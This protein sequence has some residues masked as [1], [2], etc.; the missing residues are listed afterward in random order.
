VWANL[1]G[2]V[3]VGLI[4]I[5]LWV[6]GEAAGQRLFRRTSPG[7]A[8]LAGGLAA[9]FLAVGLNPNGFHVY[10][11]PFQVLGHPE[12][13]DYITEWWSPNFHSESMHPFELFLLATIAVL[14]LARP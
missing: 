7:L 1:H 12:V 2:G 3:I 8:P 4:L 13:M 5:S 6:G 9:S 14:A 10:A 11:Y